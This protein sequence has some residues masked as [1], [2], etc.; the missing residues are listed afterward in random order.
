MEVV[1]KS[2][3]ESGLLN[4]TKDGKLAAVG[5]TVSDL[6]KVIGV[7]VRGAGENPYLPKEGELWPPT[8]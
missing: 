4:V 8:Q 7:I 5:L 6:E 2:D 3:T 1:I